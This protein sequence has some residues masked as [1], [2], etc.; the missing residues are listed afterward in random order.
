MNDTISFK[1]LSLKKRK[2][3]ILRGISVNLEF[4]KSYLLMGKNGAGKST[5]LRCL[6]GLESEYS[7]KIVFNSNN[8]KNSQHMTQGYLSD[9]LNIPDNLSLKKYAHSLIYL[10]EKQNSFDREKYNILSE[11]FSTYDFIEKRFGELSKGMKKLFFLTFALS[12]TAKI[13]LFDEP[14]EGLDIIN[15]D[16]LISVM[17][18]ETAVGN[19]IVVSTHEIELLSK[20]FDDVLTINNGE[21]SKSSM[22]GLTVKNLKRMIEQ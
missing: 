12:V 8:E 13:K 18:K 5:F 14:F 22:H 1:N 19:L 15:K 7:G 6:C 16:E 2:K 11:K 4:G 20:R 9:T 10:F 17:L 3:E 21:L